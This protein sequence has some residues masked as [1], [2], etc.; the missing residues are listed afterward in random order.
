MDNIEA[1]IKEIFAKKADIT[2]AALDTKL[3]ELN[4]DSLDLV[5]VMMEIEE[6]FSIEFANEEILELK[7]VENVLDL[8]KAKKK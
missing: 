2:N 4:I 6:A 5:E 3:S 1:K 8:V 7:T